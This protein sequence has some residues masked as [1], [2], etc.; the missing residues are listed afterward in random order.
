MC[1]SAL[2]TCTRTCFPRPKGKQQESHERSSPTENMHRQKDF[3]SLPMLW[4]LHCQYK[5][6]S[7]SPCSFGLRSEAYWSRRNRPKKAEWWM[8]KKRTQIECGFLFL[9]ARECSLLCI[10]RSKIERG[11][12]YIAGIT[13]LVLAGWILYRVGNP[14]IGN[15]LT[16]KEA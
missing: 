7:M 11:S 10:Y 5:N 13:P 2:H 4:D 9:Q 14:T 3:S 8:T 15:G 12:S 1:S 16:S 6:P